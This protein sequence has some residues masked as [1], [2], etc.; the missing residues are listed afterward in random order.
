MIDWS[1]ILRF[2]V[3]ILGGV[4]IIYKIWNHENKTFQ[5]AAIYAH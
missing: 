4:E 1:V 2:F 3:P 5:K